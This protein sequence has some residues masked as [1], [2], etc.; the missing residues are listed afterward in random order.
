V[1]EEGS[2]DSL[3]FYSL[4]TF[5]ARKISSTNVLKR[6]NKEIRRRS[7]VVGVF[8]S[9]DS[10]VRLITCFLIE[11]SEDWGTSR[12]YIKQETIEELYAIINPHPAAG[13]GSG[14]ESLEIPEV[15]KVWC[16]AAVLVACPNKWQFR[17]QVS[18]VPVGLQSIGLCRL[19]QAVEGGAGMSSSRG[20]REEPIAAP[21]HKRPNRILDQIRIWR[22]IRR[23]QIPEQLLPFFQGIVHCFTQ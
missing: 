20:T 19:N 18:E 11:Y 9:E 6:L 12:S 4:D 3:Q 13:D 8:P 22:Q 1:L 17:E 15:K 16:Q 2:E 10:Y 14:R 23:V 7:R 5:D 21:Q